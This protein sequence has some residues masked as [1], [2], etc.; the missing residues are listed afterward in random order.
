MI[1]NIK[2]T[3]FRN[4]KNKAFKF[5]KANIVVA[6][7]GR[8]K[9]NLLESIFLVSTTKTFRKANNIDL[10]LKQ[11]DFA[12]IE[13]DIL[14]DKG[15]IKIEL[16]VDLTQ[17]NHP[18]TLKI[19]SVKKPLFE[20]LGKLRTV[21]FSPE[22][23]NLIYGSP[24][25]RRKFLDIL[26]CQSDTIYA[27]NLTEY[28]HILQNKNALLKEIKKN[29]ANV[30]ELDFWNQQLSILGSKIIYKRFNV[31]KS[32]SK[33]IINI[34]QEISGKNQTVPTHEPKQGEKLE[35]LY[36]SDAHAKT[37]LKEIQLAM[38]EKIKER[39]DFEIMYG[40]SLVGPQKDDLVFK[41][42][43]FKLDVYG[44]RGEARTS[45]LTLKLAEFD[46]LLDLD[47][48]NPPVLL[49]DDPF[50]ELDDVRSKSFIKLIEKS[51]QYFITTTNINEVNGIEKGANIIEL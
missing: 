24:G 9:T 36:K 28:N 49:L 3:G 11:K 22:S 1:S 41:L 12:R 40:K 34:Y 2:L 10:I 31:I 35:I 46:Y 8:G 15:E 5:K 17:I 50:S 45:I 27:K 47:P 38:A 14:N 48:D 26:I 37:S 19:N 23:L 18:K 13:A 30:K 16:V 39:L 42:D 25:E 6:L 33:D 20:A 29:N 32:L 4:F 44:S 43:G 21:Y 7:N 51:K